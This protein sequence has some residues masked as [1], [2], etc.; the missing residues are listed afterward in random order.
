MTETAVAQRN[1]VSASGFANPLNLPANAEANSHVKVYGDD[2][3]LTLGV[4]YTLEGVGDTGNLDEIDGVD[5]T[6]EQDTLDADLYDTFTVEHDPPL[7]QDSSLSSGGTLGRVYEGGLDALARRLQAVG[8]KVDRRVALPVDVDADPVLPV[9]DPG[10]ALVWNEAGDGFANSLSNPDS[11]DLVDASAFADAA[12]ASA[13]EADASADAAAASAAAALVSE[14]ASAAS[15]QAAAEAA[16]EAGDLSSILPFL[17]PVGTSIMFNKPTAPTYFLKENGAAVSRATYAAL[18]GQIGVEYGA[19][20]GST[21]FNLPE[22][23]G[24]FFR[25]LDDGRGVDS[26]RSIATAQSEMV[27]AHTH[28]AS[29]S[30]AGSHTHTVT[31]TAN[32]RYGLNPSGA[33]A[34]DFGSSDLIKGSTSRNMSVNT[35]G[36]HTHT[37]TVNASSGTENRPRNKAKLI[38][39]KY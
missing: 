13:A 39:I 37:I 7:E 5:V 11:D 8:S 28:T 17:V 20:D 26:G 14:Q 33:T 18:F 6:I 31:M 2:T 21:T 1:T 4:D 27:G 30:S 22:S 12:A 3:L 23:R 32:A 36:A 15:A 34:A 25:G 19:G 29:M 9:P 16:A 38:C 35:T 10:K 24:E